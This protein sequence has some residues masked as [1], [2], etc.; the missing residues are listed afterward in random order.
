VQRK[1]VRPDT[2]IQAEV[3][4]RLESDIWIDDQLLDVKVKDAFVIL[5]GVVGSAEEKQRAVNR[6]YVA[7]VV[8]I[9]DGAL[10]VDLS[11]RDQLRRKT[12]LRNGLQTRTVVRDALRCDPRVGRRKVGITVRN[13]LV[14]LD[15]Q[16]DNL[17]AK[18]AAEQDAKNTIGVWRVSNLLRVRPVVIRPDDDLVLDVQAALSGDAYL[19]RHKIGVSAYNSKVYLRG[20]VD[21]QYEKDR[22]EDVAA[23]VP[24][25]VDVANHLKAG[26]GQLAKPDREIRRDVRAQLS[27]SPFVDSHDI[28]V[29]VDEGVVTLKGT[30][31]NW[32]DVQAATKNA[33]QGGAKRVVNRLKV[34]N[35]P[36]FSRPKP[37]EQPKK[38]GAIE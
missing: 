14:T 33:I 21:S 11:N 10:Q 15:G 28:E 23:R 32:R 19:H 17:K 29:L 16:V 8:G 25:V 20:S 13:G 18:K 36:D 3:Q 37:Q 30:V 26:D 6:S 38:S 34:R 27:W 31:E 35:G 2:E 5:S 1:T 12:F 4:R 22:A 7:G 24:G 9:D